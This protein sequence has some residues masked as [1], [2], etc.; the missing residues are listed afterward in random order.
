MAVIKFDKDKANT[1]IRDLNRISSEIESNLRKV[2]NNTAGKE[3]SL[4][5]SLLKVY[6]Y[7]TITEQVLQ[8][9]GTYLEESRSERYLKYDYT[10]N[11]R[12][13]NNYIRSI[14]NR[15]NSASTK[16]TQAIQQVVNALV[17]LKSLVS[18]FESDASLRMS[19][20]LEDVGQ[21]D[22]N[23]LSAYGPMSGTSQ[24]AA[25]LGAKIADEAYTSMY[26]GPLG[27][28]PTA[29]NLERLVIFDGILDLVN[30]NELAYDDKIKS[31]EGLLM[32]NVL[33]VDEEGLRARALAAYES[34]VGIA[35]G[36]NVELDE[37]LK[38]NF[39]VENG[40]NIVK[41]IT[42]AEF[43]TE[44]FGSEGSESGRKV[45]EMVGVL[46]E[47]MLN[48]D[49]EAAE[50]TLNQYIIEQEDGVKGFDLNGDGIVDIPYEPG[51]PGEKGKADFG[52][53]GDAAEAILGLDNVK[54]KENTFAHIGSVVGDAVVDAITGSSEN[55]G[56]LDGLTA[57]AGMAGSA[58]SKVISSSDSNSDFIKNMG[59][60]LSDSVISGIET[61]GAKIVDNLG[62]KDSTPVAET[63]V[64][65]PGNDGP[66]N[67]DGGH[68]KG[69]HDEG[70][71]DNIPE[72]VKVEENPRVVNSSGPGKD[73]VKREEIELPQL[74]TEIELK[75][76]DIK[77]EEELKASAIDTSYDIG[78]V[79]TPGTI[80]DVTIELPETV[81][82]KGAA[83][84]AGAAGVG[85]LGTLA[86]NSAGGN[87]PTINGLAAGEMLNMNNS[88]SNDVMAGGVMNEISGASAA[89]GGTPTVNKVSNSAVGG[90][91]T[92][93]RGSLSSANTQEKSTPAKTAAGRGGSTLEDKDQ[94]NNDNSYGKPNKAEDTE[95]NNKKGMLGDAAIAELNEK[96][97]KQIK[98]ATG[99]SAGGAL[100]SAVLAF[101]GILPSFMFI[102]LLIAIVA[103]YTTY[104]VKK[105]HDKKKRME[106]L[107]KQQAE[108]VVEEKTVIEDV[109][110]VEVT[111]EAESAPVA[112]EDVT[113]TPVPVEEQPVVSQ[114]E[115]VVASQEVAQ[116]EVQQVA[117]STNNEFSEQPYEP[118]RD[119]VVE[120]GTHHTES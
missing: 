111:T 106:A 84:I 59:K 45:G 80:K 24:I 115:E 31:I 15:S 62:G 49:A 3:I 86:S 18:E 113:A 87:A 78:D 61:A 9:D 75:P 35:T 34:M 22:F 53:V 38:V 17:K 97:E 8:E 108:V 40:V 116:A 100:G 14:M 37:N 109:Q 48:G 42:H 90:E 72:K 119:G 98:I 65:R 107:S 70:R 46:A 50:K 29:L 114:T 60:E 63:P 25:L 83:V 117:P 1:L 96:D 11:A 69:A 99:V 104:R 19:S 41:D 85:S 6:D 67:S 103:L 36:E 57:A 71:S 118:S 12:T 7:R 92:A 95:D 52:A 51:V 91:A 93:D 26:L 47:A 76:E 82:G 55:E 73:F 2:Q 64:E 4:Y 88:M 21:F 30:N 68:G 44:I 39:L 43:A 66:A 77:L 74:N 27:A 5:S 58:L 13:Y 28:R 33:E 112:S 94:N 102:L 10:S 32:G 23:F 79:K 20:S 120:I 89:S 101:A 16:A 110:N 81:E 56:V 54:D 105:K